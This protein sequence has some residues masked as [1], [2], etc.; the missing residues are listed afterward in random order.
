MVFLYP[1]FCFLHLIVRRKIKA[2]ALLS[3]GLVLATCFITYKNRPPP[4]V[5]LCTEQ[6][7]ILPLHSL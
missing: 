5:Y 3:I 4:V 6:K 2:G 1:P 7:M